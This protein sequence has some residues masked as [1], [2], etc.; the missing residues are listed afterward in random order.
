MKLDLEGGQSYEGLVKVMERSP[1]QD[2][3]FCWTSRCRSKGHT[4]FISRS[5]ISYGPST[6]ATLLSHDYIGIKKTGF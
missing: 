5:N 3:T 4:S 6:V 2:L 1:L